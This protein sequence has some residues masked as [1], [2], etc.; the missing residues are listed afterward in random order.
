MLILCEAKYFAMQSK[1]VRRRAELTEEHRS[2]TGLRGRTS[3][4]QAPFI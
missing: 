1:L 3:A 4:L 2:A